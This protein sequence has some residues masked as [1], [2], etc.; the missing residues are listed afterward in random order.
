MKRNKTYQDFQ[1]IKK[2]DLVSCRHSADDYI[3]VTNI[4]ITYHVSKSNSKRIIEKNNYKCLMPDLSIR[5]YNRSHIKKF[6]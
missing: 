4:Y 6:N 5:V 3:I 1:L 2:G